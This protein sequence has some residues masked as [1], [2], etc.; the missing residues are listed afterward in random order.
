MYYGFKKYLRIMKLLYG[1]SNNATRF[2]C[3]DVYLNVNSVKPKIDPNS[4]MTDAKRKSSVLPDCMGGG[5]MG[6]GA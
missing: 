6:L 3:K 1:A 4:T 2:G 5:P